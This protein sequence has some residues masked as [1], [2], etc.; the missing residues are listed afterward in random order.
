MSKQFFP[1]NAEAFQ[2]VGALSDTLENES[3][4]AFL[5]STAAG[6]AS[7]G[8]AAASIPSP[9]KSSPA[10]SP[11]TEDAPARAQATKAV[12]IKGAKAKAKASRVSDPSGGDHLPD[13]SKAGKADRKPLNYSAQ[14]EA[15]AVALRDVEATSSF[16]WG[17]EM[18]TG[19]KQFES[20][21]KNVQKRL[22]ACTDETEFVLK[23]GAQ[24]LQQ[25]SF[26]VGDDC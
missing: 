6:A 13:P 2:G 9:H 10:K 14:M 8:A 20:L 3:F 1:S 23:T 11:S 17:E 15:L 21:N 4:S 18:T 24:A 7:I 25:P 12:I 26:S 5:G 19:Y 22:K 16:W